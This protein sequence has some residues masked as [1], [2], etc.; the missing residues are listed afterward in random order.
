MYQYHAQGLSVRSRHEI[1]SRRKTRRKK[2]SER[3]ASERL[4]VNGWQDQITLGSMG[5]NSSFKSKIGK[6]PP[7]RLKGIVTFNRALDY[8]AMDFI[9]S[10]SPFA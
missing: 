2:Y 6:K 9:H 8:L 5:R 7:R 4:L 3:N 1:D 10:M